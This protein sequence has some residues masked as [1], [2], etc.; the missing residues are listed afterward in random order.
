MKL[1]L[2]FL[3]ILVTGTTVN[4]ETNYT[5]STPAGQGVRE[6]FGISQSDSIDF[7]R[8]HLKIIDRK[9]F[10]LSCSY[11]IAK[12]NT[13]GFINEKKVTLKG[14]A[15]F[16]E[17][18]LVLNQSGKKLSMQVL[19]DNIMHL[20]NKGGGMMVGNGGWSYTLNAMN[21]LP[22]P[23]TKLTTKNFEFKDSVV[24]E[25]RTPCRGVEELFIGRVRPECYKKKWL[26]TLYR[27]Y[28]GATTGT[29]KI[30]TV[31]SK[32]GKWKLKKSGEGKIIY[33]LDLNNGNT[34]DLLHVDANIVYMMDVKGEILVG[35][36][37]FSYSLNR[38][39][40]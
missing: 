12:P 35:D 2:V 23:A 6:F 28:G 15:S 11:G 7:I 4:K 39:M 3:C 10:N 13:N 31:E 34:L 37:D 5:A 29:Y 16:N 20:L 17:G 14:T 8:W 9:E 24:F 1:L 27:S 40:R 18:V 32:K 21:K 33:S 26:V 36:H 22:A 25:G 38:R 19:N 30:G